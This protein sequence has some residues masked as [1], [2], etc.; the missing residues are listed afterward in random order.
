M[1]DKSKSIIRMFIYQDEHIKIDK[2]KFTKH[3]FVL[4]KIN[5]TIKSKK[6]VEFLDRV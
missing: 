3:D 2:E 5:N 1:G 6:L 4:D